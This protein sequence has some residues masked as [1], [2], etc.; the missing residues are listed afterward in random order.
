MLE[1]FGQSKLWGADIP[2]PLYLFPHI[3]GRY[4]ASHAP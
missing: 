1:V 4:K 3:S 2:F